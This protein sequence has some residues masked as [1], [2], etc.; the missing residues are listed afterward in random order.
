MTSYS[1]KKM[2]PDHFHRSQIKFYVILTLFSTVTGLPILFIFAQALK[3]IDEL[4]A[5]PPRF[6]VRNPS[7]QN[8]KRLFEVIGGSDIPVSR[9]LFNS[10]ISTGLAVLL[11]LLVCTMAG[12]ALSKK[13][14][15]L[16]AAIF[17]MNTLALMFVPVAVMV[18][19]YLVICRLGLINSLWVQILPALAMPV[20][21][22]LIKQFIDQIPDELIEAARMDGAREFHIFR[23]IIIPMSRSSMATVTIL[24]FQ[25][26]WTS[27]EASSMY[28]SREELRTFPYFMSTLTSAGNGVA[29]QGMA[30]AAVLILLLPNLLIFILLQKQVMATM[31]HSG[32]K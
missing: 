14:F 22:F 21:L 8:F 15:R 7:L 5:Y 26:S 28:I 6:L 17:N 9:Y 24:A 18:P 29:G 20:G 25:T 31:A 27:I 11:T 2:N 13:K 1:G 12:Y 16:N 23:Y 3:P 10:L 4:F 32:I 19:K 30:A